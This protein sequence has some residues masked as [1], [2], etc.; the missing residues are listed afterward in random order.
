MIKG[1][2]VR[3]IKGEYKGKVAQIKSRHFNIVPKEWEDVKKAGRITTVDNEIV[4]GIKLDGE[5]E[6]IY[7]PESYLELIAD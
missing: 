1:A 5:K 4:Y 3:I 7:L 6:T 2:K